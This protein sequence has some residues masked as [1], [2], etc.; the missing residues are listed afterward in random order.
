MTHQSFLNLSLWPLKLAVFDPKLLPGVGPPE[1]SDSWRPGFESQWLYHR[2]ELYQT[3]I[4]KG[5]EIM[6]RLASY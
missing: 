4:Q 3:L 5:V 2:C 6:A 1:N